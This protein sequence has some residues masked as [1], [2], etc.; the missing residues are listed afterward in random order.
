[1]VSRSGLLPVV[2]YLDYK[3]DYEL[4]YMPEF[5]ETAR[6]PISLDALLDVFW[7]EISD[8]QVKISLKYLK[9]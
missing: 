8:A 1:M 5:L 4:K 6:V 3:L 7:K 9:D 2:C